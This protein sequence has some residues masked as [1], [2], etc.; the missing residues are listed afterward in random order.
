MASVAETF[1]AEVLARL[2]AL[3]LFGPELDNIRRSHL[4]NVT[5]ENAPAVHVRFP[6]QKPT[7]DKSCNWRWQMDFT[8]SVF[9]RDDSGDKM[10]DPMVS[11]VVRRLNN[12]ASKYTNKVTLEVDTIQTETETADSDATRVD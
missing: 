9:S 5:R 4:T 1:K 6:R 7:E 3:P 12:Q 8:V 11:E 10:A 2:V